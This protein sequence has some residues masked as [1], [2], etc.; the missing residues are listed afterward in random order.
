MT[1]FLGP[2]PIGP[3]FKKKHDIWG[4]RHVCLNKKLIRG[5]NY[6]L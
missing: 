6:G 3:S 2:V 4:F 1:H 5:E